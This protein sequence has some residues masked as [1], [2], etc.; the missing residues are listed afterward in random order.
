[1]TDKSQ[2]AMSNENEPQSTRSKKKEKMFE[3]NLGLLC[4]DYYFDL[5]I[6]KFGSFLAGGS[7]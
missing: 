4:L 1:M 7:I 6:S 5:H 2:L 3:K